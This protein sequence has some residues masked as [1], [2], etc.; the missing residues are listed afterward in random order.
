MYK[1][2]KVK[3]VARKLRYDEYVTLAEDKK[4][5]HLLAS[6]SE[7]QRESTQFNSEMRGLTLKPRLSVIEMKV[8]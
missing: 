4:Q 3:L 6:G 2:P 1:S 7:S 5:T 8:D